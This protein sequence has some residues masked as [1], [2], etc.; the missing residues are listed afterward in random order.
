MDAIMHSNKN[1][2]WVKIASSA[3]NEDESPFWSSTE[4]SHQKL[5]QKVTQISETRKIIDLDPVKLSPKNLK[6]EKLK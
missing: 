6:R 1:G 2:Q 5:Q 3:K 4:Q